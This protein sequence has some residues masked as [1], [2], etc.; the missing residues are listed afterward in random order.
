MMPLGAWFRLWLFPPAAPVNARL[1]NAPA[2]TEGVTPVQSNVEIP[3]DRLAILKQVQ[4]RQHS[5]IN[6]L[7]SARLRREVFQHR[8]ERGGQPS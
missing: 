3:S 8:S 5:I 6:R 1:T 4:E 2:T 7:T